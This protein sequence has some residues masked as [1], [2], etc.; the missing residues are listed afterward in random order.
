MINVTQYC[1]FSIDQYCTI[2]IVLL[3]FSIFNS[4]ENVGQYCNMY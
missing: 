4:N 1:T 3:L 2:D